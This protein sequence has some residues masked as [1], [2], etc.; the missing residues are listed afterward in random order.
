MTELKKVRRV[1]NPQGTRVHGV[2]ETTSRGV[3]LCGIQVDPPLASAGWKWGGE[4][5]RC[6]LCRQRAWKMGREWEG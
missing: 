2:L 6:L 4:A 3:T 5:P 1:T